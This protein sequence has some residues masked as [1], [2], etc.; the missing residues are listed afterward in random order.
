MKAGIVIYGAVLP[1]DKDLGP[2]S[3]QTGHAEIGS[4]G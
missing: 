2:Y 4:L 1:G 3:T